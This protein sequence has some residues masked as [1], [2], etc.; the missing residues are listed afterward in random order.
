MGRAPDVASRLP[1][2]RL[3]G[4]TLETG[5]SFETPLP[6][7]DMAPDL[8]FTLERRDA[9][10]LVQP[11]VPPAFESPLRFEDGAPFLSLY[12]M[13][14]EDLLRF[15]GVADF[16]LS[17]HQ[18][19]C[20][21]VD[22]AY[23][24]QVEVHLLGLVFAYWF[25]RQGIP[26]LHAST[27]KIDDRAVGFMATNKGGKS[28]LA[29]CLMQLGHPLLSDDLVGI[30]SSRKGILARPGFP[31]MRLWPDQASW[32]TDGWK[33]LPLAHHTV[34]KRRLPVGPQGFGTFR[35]ESLPLACIYLPERRPAE[36]E[37][38]RVGFR[39]V[40]PREAV[41]ELLRGSFTPRLVKG[42]GLA[43]QRLER[44]ARLATTVPVRQLHYSEG[45]EFLPAVGAR[46][47]E[48]VRNGPEE[49]GGGQSG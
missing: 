45:V 40:P 19:T 1:R 44:L 48:D 21:L 34:E 46:I 26:M 8:A 35:D 18:I 4:V 42:A 33:E 36:G 10:E 6:S 32:F 49:S 23:A 15:P 2:Y 25:E 27:V 17:G 28:S 38:L 31:S 29:A 12:R 14:D 39:T 41:I 9:A 43:P 30:E 20:H 47:I 13:G 37:D 11:T 22:D 5:F 7:T 16:V 24:H 3:F